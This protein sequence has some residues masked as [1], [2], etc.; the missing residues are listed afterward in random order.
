MEY[1]TVAVVVVI[2]VIIIGLEMAVLSE[3]KAKAVVQR[4]LDK[5]SDEHHIAL[6]ENEYLN[7]VVALNQLPHFPKRTPSEW[8]KRQRD[9]EGRA[10]GRRMADRFT[11]PKPG[12]D[13][14]DDKFAGMGS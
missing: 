3:R 2:M 14:D 6:N 9:E 11:S 13:W 4:K 12:I 10:L 5:L 7:A 8:T 1:L